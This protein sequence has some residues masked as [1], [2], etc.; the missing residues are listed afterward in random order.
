MKKILLIALALFLFPFAA[1]SVHASGLGFYA[2]SGSGDSDIDVGPF[3]WLVTNSTV[4]SIADLSTES[5]GLVFDTNLSEDRLFNYRLELGTGNY[6][7]EIPGSEKTELK[8]NVMSHDFGFGVL[9]NRAVRL[10]LGPEI[11]LT[12]INAGANG[13]DYDLLGFGFGLALGLNINLKGPVTIA[14]KAGSLNQIVN[15][16]V[17][18][19]DN[20]S[21]DVSSDDNVSFVS[22]ALMFRLGERF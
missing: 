20:T 17:T 11:M 18:Y 5:V 16:D 10:W 4:S 21:D 14:I 2:S 12:R 15:G 19:P 1:A 6:T 8:Q 22:A 9:R 7:W 13:N 3:W